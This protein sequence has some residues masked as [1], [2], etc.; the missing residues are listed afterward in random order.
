MEGTYGRNSDSG[1]DAGGPACQRGMSWGSRKSGGVRTPSLPAPPSPSSAKFAWARILRLAT[2]GPRGFLLEPGEPGSPEVSG[3]VRRRPLGNGKTLAS[4]GGGM[5][6]RSARRRGQRVGLPPSI[7]VRSL[8]CRQPGLA[9]LSACE[10]RKAL[11]EGPALVSSAPAGRYG[12]ARVEL[13]PVSSSWLVSPTETGRERPKPGP[14]GT[15][16]DTSSID[17]LSCIL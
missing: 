16:H 7:S 15:S 10:P 17:G 11:A 4:N 9:S 1:K 6:K 12:K 2:P 3:F 13:S 8:F 14:R 5:G